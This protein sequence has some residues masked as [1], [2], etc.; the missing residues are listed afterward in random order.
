M[1]EIELLY[2]KVN[3]ALSCLC[4]KQHSI[5]MTKSRIESDFRE[6]LLNIDTELEEALSEISSIEK[7]V[8]GFINI[9]SAHAVRLY[10]SGDIQEYDS[11]LLSRLA[12]Q[13]NNASK[14][15]RYAEELYTVA[16]SQLRFIEK[17]KYVIQQE[18]IN[19]KQVSER[20]CRIAQINIKKEEDQLTQ[21]VLQCIDSSDFFELINL[22][23]ADQMIYDSSHSINSSINEYSKQIS[24]GVCS[25]PLSVPKGFENRIAAAS[26]GQYTIS[27][28]SLRCPFSFMLNSGHSFLIEFHNEYEEAMNRGIQNFLFNIIRNDKNEFTQIVFIDPIRYNSSA[29]GVLSRFSLGDNSIID[30]VPLSNEEVKTKLAEILHDISI[31][32]KNRTA[33]EEAVFA[34]RIVILHGYPYA[35]DSSI[36]TKIQQLIVNAVHHNLLIIVTHNTS[37]KSGYSFDGNLIKSVSTQITSN[38]NGFSIIYNGKKTHFSWYSIATAI[39]DDIIQ[40]LISKHPQ[41]LC[42]NDYIKRIGLSISRSNKGM[43]E[44]VNIPYG[45]D[46]EGNV[47]TLD[48]E[49][50]NFA[51]FICG[52]ARSG[53]STLLHTILTYIIQNYHPDDVEIWLIDFKMTE[54]SRYI[55]HLPPHIR[56]I[57][58]DESPELVYDL[59]DRLVEVLEKRQSLFMERWLKLSDVPI[60]K[61]MPSIFV[62]IDEFSIMSQILADSV[63]S[64][65][66]DYTLKLQKLLAK[67]AALGFHFIFA[68]QGF[69]DGSRGLTPF[70]KKQI[71]LRL[72]MKTDYVEIKETLDLK[73]ISDED[74]KMM[75]QLEP[76][77]V[78]VRIH[79]DEIGNH[80]RLAKTIYISDYTKQDDMIE[81]INN[82]YT[83]V[84]RYVPDDTAG[85]IDKKTVIVNGNRYKSFDDQR[86]NITQ[87]V[88][89]KLSTEDH[90]DYLFIGDPK[91]LISIF[92][93]EVY[94]GF[95]ENILMFVPA[96]EADPGI[97]IILSI[98]HS[99]ELCHRKVSILT[100]RRNALFRKMPLSQLSNVLSISKEIEDVCRT[101]RHFRI[102][103]ETK[104]QGDEYI[105]I[106]GADTLLL[107]MSCFNSAEFSHPRNPYDSLSNIGI[108]KRKENEPDILT[109]L[110]IAENDDMPYYQ[111]DDDTIS[112]QKEVAFEE[113]VLYDARD[114][115]NYIITHG[116][117]LG[118]HFIFVFSNVGEF[119]QCKLSASLFK[120]KITFR[121]PKSDAMDLFGASKSNSVLNLSEH[122]Y[123][124]SNGLDSVSFRPFM[125]P[126]LT[127]DGWVM[128][129]NSV[130]M[131]VLDEDEYLL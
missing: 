14:N 45:V 24:L 113:S 63:I 92:P 93:I 9:A 26:K 129:G 110:A 74:R 6:D 60:E 23:Q 12:V 52:A 13:I 71:Q 100:N 116:P 15:D 87:Y 81:E 8:N 94:D 30:N 77:Y 35:Y 88:N 131:S 39:P 98:S 65:S 72:A 108:E 112:S 122:C 89:S 109:L 53:K 90:I 1:S 86:E 19:K 97:S 95:S 43:R 16:T 62:V 96:Y 107:D 18:A 127:W 126:S 84:S 51:T 85:F 120:H 7:R 123:R 21:L 3:S 4:E 70:S 11:G 10:D 118:Y 27:T 46:D 80:L 20:K 69:T 25:L 91:R 17:Q 37:A 31:V 76:H 79:E 105:V 48:F 34:K 117:R 38:E 82:L 36:L 125:Y 42:D 102:K 130:T 55:N 68:S 114:D 73:S 40:R 119:N 124:Y 66:E 50:S 75:E 106:F 32:E 101:I 99:L 121:L 41:K 115:L 58:L 33:N 22:L 56:Y 128:N 47:L 78:L 61:Y 49:N 2:Q 67:G 28:S 44:L 111:N 59:I 54:F 103:I 29:L 64:A 57:I 104:V 83:S 5:E